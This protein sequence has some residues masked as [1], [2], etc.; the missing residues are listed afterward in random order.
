[1]AHKLGAFHHLPHGVANAILITDIMRYNIAEAPQKM[2]TFSQY[3]YPNALPRYC[4][5]ARF[6]GVTGDTDEEVFENFIVKIE[7]LK[8]RV[9]IKKTIRDYGVTEE[10]FLATLDEMCEQAFDDQCTGA[11]PRYPLISEIKAMYL[12]AFYGETPAEEKD[13]AE[14]GA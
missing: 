1:M 6:V 3:P 5:C 9:G 13:S 10:D 2:G 14:K 12:K 4:E 8:A 7:E 11:N